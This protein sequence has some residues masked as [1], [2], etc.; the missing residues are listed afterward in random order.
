MSIVPATRVI[1]VAKTGT[2]MLNQFNSAESLIQSAGKL[3]RLSGGVRQGFVKG[4]A[5]AIFK[6]ITNGGTVLLCSS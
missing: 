3:E 2:K 5:D 4:N 6:S 1:R